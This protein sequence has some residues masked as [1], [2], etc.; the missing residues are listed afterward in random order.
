MNDVQIEDYRKFADAVE[1]ILLGDAPPPSFT[2]VEEDDLAPR[3]FESELAAI[4]AAS[5]RGLVRLI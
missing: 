1:R 3:R 4:I 5:E 2:P